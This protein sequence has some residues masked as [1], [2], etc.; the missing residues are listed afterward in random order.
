MQYNSVVIFTTGA[1]G[2]GK[3]YSR[4]A[5]YLYDFWLPERKGIHYSNF[6]VKVEKFAEKYPDA[7]ERIKTIPNEELDRWS[8]YESGPWEYFKEL[9]LEGAHIAIDECH[10]FIKR[11]G[12]GC[13][14]NATRWEQ[15]LGEIRHRGC[16]VEFLSQDPHK[17]SKCIDIHAGVRIALINSEDRRDP[18]FGIPLGDWYE[19]RAGISREYET[20]IWQIEERRIN[21]KWVHGHTE[22]FTLKPFYFELYDSFNTPHSG[23]TKAAG[24]ER[25]YQKRS[26]AGLV[27]WFCRRN[28]F[29]LGSRV[30]IVMAFVW[31]CFC[32]GLNW[33]IFRYINFSQSMAESN[34]EVKP[35][36][37]T[38][39]PAPRPPTPEPE[40]AK[41]AHVPLP[42][43][44]STA[45]A[46]PKLTSG[47]VVEPPKSLNVESSAATTKP[48]VTAPAHPSTAEFIS[49]ERA[50]YIVGAVSMNFAAMA[51]GRLLRVGDLI[52]EFVFVRVEYP[53]RACVF[54]GTDGKELLVCVGGS[55][56]R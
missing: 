48:E 2:T 1:P 9:D 55:V 35:P 53:L 56:R 31:L 32:G 14:K 17:V 40:S 51:D 34:R 23:G 21:S 3:T 7:A 22:R 4:C 46:Q 15:W 30:V 25:E 16:T 42:E 39:K 38:K 54:R 5:R 50:R 26:I 27:S 41:A 45:L 19:L 20:V 33:L 29:R 18:W 10:N 24:Q 36:S 52:G 43:P 49:V 44:R 13:Q 11:T 8:R 6:P 47:T 28:L 12:E 37:E